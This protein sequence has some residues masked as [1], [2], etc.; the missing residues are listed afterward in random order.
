MDAVRTN[1]RPKSY[2]LK[3]FFRHYIETKLEENGLS[4]ESCVP[5]VLNQITRSILAQHE[6]VFKDGGRKF[7][8]SNKLYLFGVELAPKLQMLHDEFITTYHPKKKK[9]SGGIK[10]EHKNSDE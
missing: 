6:A 1:N 10:E 8:R 2:I 9:S 3:P 7:K 5:N 4:K